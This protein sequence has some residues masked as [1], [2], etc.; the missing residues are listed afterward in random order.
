MSERERDRSGWH[1]RGPEGGEEEEDG[2]KGR[3]PGEGWT[4][5]KEQC[6]EPRGNV[7][8]LAHGLIKGNLAPRIRGDGGKPEGERG[9]QVGVER[10]GIA[11]GTKNLMNMKYA[12]NLLFFSVP[13]LFLQ[14][15]IKNNVNLNYSKGLAKQS[16]WNY[17]IIVL[18]LM[19]FIS[20]IVII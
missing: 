18:I 10:E 1:W 4:L 14:L 11:K 5:D 19:A 7:S 2:G 12:L 20:T 15:K 13:C 17:F 8:S 6:T 9:F 3:V 16:I